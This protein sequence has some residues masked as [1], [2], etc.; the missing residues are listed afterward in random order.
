MIT[1]KIQGGLGNQLFQYT[2]ARALSLRYGMPFEMDVTNYDHA[3]LPEDHPDRRFK[4]GYGL[5]QFNTIEKFSDAKTIAHF[6]KYKLH[7][8]KIW[9]LYDT[10]IADES[11]YI[12]ERQSQ[13][14]EDYAHPKRLAAGGSV[15]AEG[16]WLTEKYFAEYADTIRKELSF[17]HPAEGISSELIA[18]MA[19]SNSVSLHVRRGNFVIQQYNNVHGVCS[20]DYFEKAVAE[21][22]KRVENPE[23]FIFSDDHEWVRDNLKLEYP[24]TFVTHNG[25]DKDY[26]DLRLM[27][28]CKHHINANSTFSWWGAWLSNDPDKVVVVPDKLM[29][30]KFNS[31]DYTPADWI[32]IPTELV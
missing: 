19:S 12:E 32:Q 6:Q 30:K 14:S 18:R 23:F 1:I 3:N 21:I 2:Y 31:S 24:T 16:Y 26:D 4:R 13:F 29:K 28:A 10:L 11:R 9:W 27:A 8:R 7:R 15:Y 17:K 22:V 25:P 5:G 20:L